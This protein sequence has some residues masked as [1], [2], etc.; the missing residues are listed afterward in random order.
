MPGVG[1]P[2]LTPA[3]RAL[4]SGSLGESALPGHVIQLLSHFTL[5]SLRLK[6]PVPARELQKSRQNRRGMWKAARWSGSRSLA[7]C[8]LPAAQRNSSGDVSGLCAMAA[9]SLRA[10]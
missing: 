10:E 2:E 1:L 6:E 5:T 3:C 4:P 9:C 8:F 7:P